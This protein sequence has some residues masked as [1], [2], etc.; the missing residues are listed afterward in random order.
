MNL[1]GI[2][3]L[4]TLSAMSGSAPTAREPSLRYYGEPVGPPFPR[5]RQQR[6]AMER[7]STKALRQVT[8]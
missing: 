5:T 7:A 2:A 4:A 1:I 6:R 3:A 8:N